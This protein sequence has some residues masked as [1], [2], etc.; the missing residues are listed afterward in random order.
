VRDQSGAI[1]RGLTAANFTI[2]E[3]GKPQKIDAFTFQEISDQPR[4]PLETTSILAGVE[5]RLKEEVQRAAGA[6]PA[7]A[8]AATV[9]EEEASDLLGRRLVVL[10]F[11]ISSMQPEDVQR[12][13]DSANKFVAEQMSPADLV[14]VATVSTAL[15]V[16]TD[17]SGDRT[18]VAA[19]LAQLAYTE[20]TATPPPDAS[21]AAT[22]EAAAAATE[23]TA[24][25]TSEMD[26]FNNDVRLRALRTLA[27]SLG[28]VE[29]K[30]AIL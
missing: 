26:M 27:E 23:A 16:L 3:D 28:P 20:G 19:S 17:F 18:K 7:V 29:Q 10:L 13:V 6:A 9:S 21:T 8:A 2:L 22:D 11:D 30:K 5:D 25:E 4:K 1:V 14:A 24:A 12:A 15:D